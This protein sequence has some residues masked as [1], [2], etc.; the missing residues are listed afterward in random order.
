MLHSCATDIVQYCDL[1]ADSA[2]TLHAV[3][4]V[5]DVWVAFIAHLFAEREIQLVPI[6][7]GALT[8]ALEGLC[9][10]KLTESKDRSTQHST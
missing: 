10:P 1:Y 9:K 5:P 7:V 4:F 8:P 2:Y 6:M 3:F